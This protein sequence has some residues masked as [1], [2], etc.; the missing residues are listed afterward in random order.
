MNKN[1]QI[2]LLIILIIFICIIIIYSIKENFIILTNAFAGSNKCL[3]INN[4]G[5]NNTLIMNPCSDNNTGQQWSGIYLNNSNNSNSN[6]SNS[7]SYN[8]NNITNS[9]IGTNN[10]LDIDNSQNSVIMNQCTNSNTQ[11]WTIKKYN[12]SD[13][14]YT[15]SSNN[16][17]NKCIDIIN[18]GVNNNKLN[19]KP[20][21]AYSGQLWKIQ[22]DNTKL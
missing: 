20:C 9:F 2:I 1:K 8:F 5:P 6:N 12:D 22:T 16:L 13:D 17:N 10:C 21:G 4:N 3:D 15:I 11:T 19:I 18:D 14:Y 7:N